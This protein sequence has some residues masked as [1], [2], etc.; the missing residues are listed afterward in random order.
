[1][2]ALL[3]SKVPTHVYIY[4]EYSINIQDLKNLINKDQNPYVLGI[5]LKSTH[6]IR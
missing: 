4:I 1:M 5:D 2:A 6:I 3:L